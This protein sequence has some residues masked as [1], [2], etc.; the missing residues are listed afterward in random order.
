[1][2][3]WPKVLIVLFCTIF[4]SSAQYNLSVPC[5]TQTTTPSL[6]NTYQFEPTLDSTRILTLTDQVHGTRSSN[7]PVSA[8]GENVLFGI[9][10]TEFDTHHPA[11]LDSNG[12]TRFIALWD[13]ATE[14]VKGQNRFGY[15]VIKK[16]DELLVDSLFGT[17][18]GHDHGTQMAS[19][20]AGSDRAYDYYGIAPDVKIA[21]VVYIGKPDNLIDGIKWIFSLADS[22]NLPCVINISIGVS[23]GPHDGT[24]KFD[25]FVDSICGPG[26]IIVGAAGNDFVKGTHTL[27]RIPKDDS[28]GTWL[29]PMDLKGTGEYFRSGIDIWGETQKVFTVTPLLIDTISKSIRSLRSSSTKRATSIT[30]RMLWFNN[31]GSV[32]TVLL[33]L[34]TEPSSQL[35]NK[36]HCTVEFQS[37]NPNIFAGVKITNNSDSCNIH[38]WHTHKG[39]LLSL[40]LSGFIGGDAEYNI[41]EIG[42]TAKRMIVSGS[43]IGRT[44]LT[45]WNDSVEVSASP[46]GGI[47]HFSSN[48]PTVDG[49]VKPDIVAPGWRIVSA[50]SRKAGD[51]IIPVVWPDVNKTTGRYGEAT[52]TSASAPVV[53]GIIA[54]MLQIDPKLTPE[55]ALALI[56]KSAIKDHWTGEITLPINRWGAGKINA[57]GALQE[58]INHT[59]A[60]KSKKLISSKPLGIRQYN[61]VITIDNFPNNGTASLYDLSGRK[62]ATFL[63]KQSNKII[64]PSEIATGLYTLVIFNK[65]KSTTGAF[66]V[67]LNR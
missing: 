63:L 21:A 16:H 18:V 31:D 23:V 49:R 2:I 36:A 8:T 44:N 10:D 42:G 6:F 26:K 33:D 54:L 13:Q 30:E 19:I 7:L 39:A 3:F 9:L 28:S 29:L 11:F 64:I 15:G 45:F 1:M 53:C 17:R 5:N 46:S 34:N 37:T 61:R 66:K 27:F 56:Q 14:S 58:L 48:G 22:L 20:A 60:S 47:T 52:G 62:L 4:C 55:F 43:Y 25:R 35:N 50:I 59:S 67:V 40:N 12:K 57:A 51:A 41:N 32:D 38:A 65:S 24:S